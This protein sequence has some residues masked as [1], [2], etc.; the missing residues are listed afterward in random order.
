M[1]NNDA[2]GSHYF[3]P[4]EFEYM[5]R[6]IRINDQAFQAEIWMNRS[7]KIAIEHALTVVNLCAF[8]GRGT[9]NCNRAVK[10]LITLGHWNEAYAKQQGYTFQ[11]VT[12]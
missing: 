1:N 7:P 4:Y 2:L 9:N 8:G 12:E 6:N 3:Y 11:Q 5:G 10:V